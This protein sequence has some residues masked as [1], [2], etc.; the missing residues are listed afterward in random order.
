MA[1]ER[2]RG[3]LWER[4]RKAAF[5]RDKK[6]NAECW[7]CRGAR[8]PI[9]YA[10]KPSSSPLSYEPDHYLPVKDHPE[11]EFDLAN[12]RAAHKT[13][14]RQRGARVHVDVLGNRSRDWSKRRG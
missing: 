14:N 6:A 5:K 3:P 9:D 12:I 13:C 2:K 8:G 10:A 1:G 4:T 7:I 11:L